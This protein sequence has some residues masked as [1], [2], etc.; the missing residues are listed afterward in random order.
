MSADPVAERADVDVGVRISPQRRDVDEF[1]VARC[2]AF[3][4]GEDDRCFFEVGRRFGADV[5]VVGVG[6][7]GAA[8]V[9]AEVRSPDTHEA[10]R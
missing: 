9:D 4:A 7:G 5:E 3:V 10:A 8:Q 6:F 1:G 2:V